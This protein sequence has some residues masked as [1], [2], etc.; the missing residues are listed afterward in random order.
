VDPTADSLQ[1]ALADPPALNES[2]L[3][4]S[5]PYIGQ[6]NRLV[7]TTNWEKGRIIADWRDA[8]IAQDVPVTE[9]SDEA[10]SRLVGGVSSQHVGRLRRVF[11]RFGQVQ[12]Q[13]R[14][15][16]WSHF[17]AALDW[18]DAEMW[19]EGARASDCSVAQ[20]RLTRWKT[21]G[22]L[23][24]DRPPTEDSFAT[25]MDEDFV[26]AG[27]REGGAASQDA[28]LG[29]ITGEYVE[30]AGLAEDGPDGDDD[31]TSGVTGTEPPSANG[32]DSA[33]A[34]ELIRPFEDLPELPDDLAEAFDAMKLAILRHKTDGWRHITARDVLRTLDALKALVAAP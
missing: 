2:L 6:W 14:G 31:S 3:V 22:G 34:V 21:L 23:E 9:Y 10:W 29:A 1:P 15:L 8:L 5:Q 30:V 19:L 11:Q 20:M 13:Y 4:A 12:K 32:D 27:E 17:Q 33:Q 25:E 26:P 16:Y 24:A 18:Q 28:Q 7:S